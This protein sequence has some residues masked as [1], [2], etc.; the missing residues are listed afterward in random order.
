MNSFAPRVDPNLKKIGYNDRT[1]Y[2]HRIR[3]GGGFYTAHCEPGT[4]I[5]RFAEPE[6]AESMIRRPCKKCFPKGEPTVEHPEDKLDVIREKVEEIVTRPNQ[7]DAE[8]AQAILG[9]WN[10]LVQYLY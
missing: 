7:N 1:K 6:E 9:F 4:R 8:Q 10:W 2:Y 5:T 3:F